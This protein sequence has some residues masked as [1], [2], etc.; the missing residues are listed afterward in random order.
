MRLFVIG[1]EGQVARSLREA[2]ARSDNI[3]FGFG[4]RP[5]VDLSRPA[6]IAKALADFRPD[7]VVNPAAYTAVDK[8]ESE[9]DQ[10]FAVNRDGARAV[11]AA[12]ADRGVPVI[13]L[14][15]DYVFDGKKKGPYSETDSVRPQG[16]YGQSKLE[17]ELAVAEANPKHIVLQNVVGLRPVRQQFRAHHAS[18]GGRARSA[19]GGRRPVWM[20]DLCAGYRRGHHRD[21]TEMGGFGLALRSMRASPILPARTF[22]P[23]A[24]S[25]GRSFSG[26][27]SG[28]GALFRLTRSPLPTIPRRRR[29]RPIPACRAK[30]WQAVFGLRLPPLTSSL[31]DCLDR[32]LRH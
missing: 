21:R 15:T 12:A 9:P 4:A 26:P 19:A 6:S 2:A 13:H 29:G 16:V 25:R 5:D 3:V 22:G 14:S 11:A 1:G 28:A 32:L 23:G 10:A 17:G 20:S 7:L 31:D 8:A 30:G 24:G 27:Q 18:P